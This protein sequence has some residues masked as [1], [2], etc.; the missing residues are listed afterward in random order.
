MS[1][2]ALVGVHGLRRD[3]GRHMEVQGSV[4]EVE[5]YVWRYFGGIDVGNCNGG[6]WN[7]NMVKTH[8]G[9]GDLGV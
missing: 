6:G 5:T 2:A 8:G 3:D 9:S 1:L 7:G 4:E